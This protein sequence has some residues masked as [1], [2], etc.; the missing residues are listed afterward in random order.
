MRLNFERASAST[1][2]KVIWNCK[3]NYGKI[4]VHF[5]P[6]AKEWEK[7]M[8]I[9]IETPNGDNIKYTGSPEYLDSAEPDAMPEVEGFVGDAISNFVSVLADEDNPRIEV[10]LP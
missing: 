9:R 1:P 7:T 5:E 10:K 2:N 6:E 8:Y 3:C 4:T